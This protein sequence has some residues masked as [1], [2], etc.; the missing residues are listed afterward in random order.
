MI[1]EAKD[2]LRTRQKV[3]LAMVIINIAVFLLAE[4]R[5]DTGSV[6]YMLRIGAA[7]TP[8]IRQGEYWRMF[9]AM[10]LHFGLV[11]LVYNMICLIAI[12]DLLERAVGAARYLVIYLTGGIAGNLLSMGW[13]MTTGRYAVSAGASGAISAVIGAYL[14]VLLKYKNRTDSRMIKRLAVMAFL[15]IAEGFTQAGTDNAAHIG[16]MLCGFLLGLLIS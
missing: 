10:F 11:H 7:Y 6:E 9:T 1:Q 2:F 13:E 15:M 4:L 16:G 14:A 5:G 8:A 12:G 3:N